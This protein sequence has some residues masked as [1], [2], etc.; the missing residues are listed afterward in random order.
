MELIDAVKVNL[1][2]VTLKNIKKDMANS[3]C[4]FTLADRN[5]NME[6]MRENFLNI[7][8]AKD[9]IF[10]LK[11]EDYISG[12]SVDHDPK[13]EGVIYV[14]KT[15]HIIEKTIYIKIRYV[16]GKAVVCISFHLDEI[17]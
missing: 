3:N 17:V 1:I 8:D 15:K 9:I 10:N 4:K 7:E 5:K 13:Y 14:F 16:Q 11:P 6:F 12:P 2:K